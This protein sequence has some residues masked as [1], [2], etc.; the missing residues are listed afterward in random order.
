MNEKKVYC[1]TVRSGR[2]KATGVH[3][4]PGAQDMVKQMTGLSVIPGTFNI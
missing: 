4:E 3:S 1:A 2:G